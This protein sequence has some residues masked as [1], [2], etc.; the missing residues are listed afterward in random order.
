MC[1]HQIFYLLNPFNFYTLHHLKFYIVMPIEITRIFDI[2]Y[3]QLEKYNLEK[4]LVTK[5]SGH[6]KATSNQ[7]YIDQ[8][9]AISRGLI[10]LGVKTN[11]KIALISSTNRTE[12]SIM[13]IGILQIGAQDVPI[14]PTISKEDYEYVLNHSEA[15]YCFVSDA[16]V[17]EKLN[18][19]KGILS[20]NTR[21]RHWWQLVN[22]N[23][24]KLFLALGN[25][26]LCLL[27]SRNGENYF[28][29]KI[30]KL[31]DF[32]LE[33]KLFN[34]NISIIDYISQNKTAMG[35]VTQAYFKSENRSESIILFPN[36]EDEKSEKFLQATGTIIINKE[37]RDK[38]YMQNFIYYL[39]KYLYENE[40]KVQL[41]NLG[42]SSF[43]EVLD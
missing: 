5:S 40:N 6:W 32:F 31:S 4:A 14:Y 37:D 10:Q 29:K 26:E 18:Q 21:Y 11:D 9:N 23:K 7:E 12:W 16:A 36:E 2:P 42:I 43:D 34:H 15:T 30:L 39:K 41:L 17:L 22:R 33:R 19:I 20:G 13:D 28:L 25:I 35:V 3:Y 38:T 1:I 8:A 27:D 24:R